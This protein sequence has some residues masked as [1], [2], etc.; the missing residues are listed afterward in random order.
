M[1]KITTII[2]IITILVA[3]VLSIFF[4]DFNQS[5]RYLQFNSYKKEFIAINYNE[6]RTL[7]SLVIDKILQLAEDNGV[8]IQK[9]NF[10][11]NQP[12]VRNIYISFE[13]TEE[14]YKFIGE[15][16]RLKRLND[17]TNKNDGF[18]STY[19]HNDKNQIAI[20]PDLM[21][22]NYYNYYTFDKLLSDGDNLYGEYIVYYKGNN[23]FA[24]FSSDVSELLGQDISSNSHFN[25]LTKYTIIA[26]LISVS[27]ML[28]FY[29]IFQIYDTYYKSQKIG[30]MKLLGYSE[31]KITSLLI[32]K[33]IKIYFLFSLFTLLILLILIKN[34]TFSNLIFLFNVNFILILL[35]IIINYVCVKIIFGGYN[36]SNILKKQNIALKISKTSLKLKVVTT[37][38]FIITL[39][40]SFQQLSPI[41][42]ELK[43]YR[44]AKELLQYGV[45]A[46]FNADAKEIYDYEKHSELYKLIA[47]NPELNTFYSSF[48][49][50][51]VMNEE[52][53]RNSNLLEEQGTYFR[54]GSIDKNYLKKESIVVYDVNN[55]LV[56]IDKI[57][58]TFFLFPK[59]KYGKIEKFEEFYK[60][61]SADDYIKYNIENDFVAYIYDDQTINSY[62]LDLKTKYVSSPILRVIDE[63]VR[64]SYI[65]TPLGINTFGTSL[66]TSLKIEIKNNKK[67]T[68]EILEKDIEK[69][70]LKNLIGLDNFISFSD[71]FESEIRLSRI[72][73]F[74][75]LTLIS[76]IF[77]VYLIISMQIISLYIKSDKQRVNVKY[78]LG[79]GKKKIFSIIVNKNAMYNVIAFIIAIVILVLTEQLNILFYLISISAFAVIDLIV[80]FTIIRT[81]DFSK[82]YLQ[83]KGG[84]YD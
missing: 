34:I 21:E 51:G 72:V 50:Y 81:Y 31:S 32:K 53:Q 65:E 73:S 36:V 59:S 4:L 3:I 62:R 38:L 16:L 60:K 22:N 18:I 29:F 84:N 7:D 70:G 58:S 66:G 68:F 27:I 11:H 37:V 83:L 5:K 67:E 46:T 52:E 47:R 80:L 42:S 48:D 13:T 39:C 76:I 33:R 20:I 74:V 71:Y 55:H 2:P 61:R 17:Y 75:A 77:G 10:S 64:L 82:M 78:L 14:L 40:I 57:N 24:K 6:D 26:L 8:I 23:D 15:N 41:Y 44:D 79:Y 25:D 43:V 19:Q 28:L 35:T 1:K 63:A 30:C 69:A 54:Y 9:M 45:I 12:D 49:N 56:D